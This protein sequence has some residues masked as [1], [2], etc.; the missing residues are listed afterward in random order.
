MAIH[1]FCFDMTAAANSHWLLD[2]SIYF[3]RGYFGLPE[4]LVDDNGEP[5]GGLHGFASALVTALIRH[6]LRPGAVAFDESLGT[7]FRNELYPAYKANRAPPDDNIIYQFA[8]CEQLCELLGVAS[9][10]DTRFEAD[11]I[12]ATLA[13][14]SRSQCVIYSKDKDLRQL[15]TKKCR[16]ADLLS[17]AGFDE[18]GFRSE[19]GFKPALFPDYQALVGDTSDNVPGVP[20]FGPKTAGKLVSRY[21]GLEAIVKSINRWSDDEVGVPSGGKLAVGLEEHAQQAL[22]M[23]EVLKLVKRVPLP[24]APMR[25]TRADFAGLGEFVEAKK[26]RG[27]GAMIKRH[28]KVLGER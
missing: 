18:A 24:N 4:S 27:V 16:I 10:G 3:F 9:Y 23:R 5:C 2:G 8:Q 12:L 19:Y 1:E 25:R 17:D 20:G 11:D 22:A 6:P 15:V 13:R 26:L 7:C 28:R 14:R 21:G